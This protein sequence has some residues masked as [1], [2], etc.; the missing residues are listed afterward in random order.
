[1]SKLL[2]LILFK[3]EKILKKGK[4]NSLLRQHRLGRM[5]TRE[6]QAGPT[7]SVNHPVYNCVRLREETE[8]ILGNSALNLL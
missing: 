6:D 2:F 1:M 7:I 4:N 5:K 3:V 8:L